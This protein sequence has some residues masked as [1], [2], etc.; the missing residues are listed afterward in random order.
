VGDQVYISPSPMVPSASL[1][2]KWMGPLLVILT[3]PTVAKLQ[4]HPS[5]VHLSRLK[6]QTPSFHSTPKD[7]L[8]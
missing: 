6:L 4:G 1:S 2:P 7:P 5:W 3:T 8:L